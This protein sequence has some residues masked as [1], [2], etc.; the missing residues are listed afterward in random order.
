MVRDVADHV[1]GQ[2]ATAGDRRALM[3][4]FDRE[5][6]LRAL[7]R[8]ALLRVARSG[9]PAPTPPAAPPLR[10]ALEAHCRACH[11]SGAH[12]FP[13]ERAPSRALLHD[14]LRRVAFGDMPPP[15]AEID[16]EARRAL[17]RA[18][19]AALWD[20][21]ASRREAAGYFEGSLRGLRVHRGSAILGL[22]GERARA[23]DAEASSWTFS[24]ADRHDAVTARPSFVLTFAL[25]ALRTCRAAGHTGR[26]L[27]ACLARA[28][29][30]GAAL[31]GPPR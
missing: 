31:K 26:A 3:Q 10:E 1:F 19:I 25:A 2:E 9:P 11:D 18:L 12:A 27:D 7:M 20:D 24:D 29:D 8:E 30:V 28:L 13:R 5:G 22:I 21:P 6:T 17:V 15:P 14:M 23:R 16:P 4:A